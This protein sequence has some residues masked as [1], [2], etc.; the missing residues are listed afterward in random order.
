MN[1][2]Q[3]VVLL[4]ALL[5]GMAWKSERGMGPRQILV[6]LIALLLCVGWALL[7]WPGSSSHGQFYAYPAS[8]PLF[9]FWA[10]G[11]SVVFVPTFFILR[12]RK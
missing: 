5:F 8:L 10:L 12:G 6:M 2:L 11:W 7:T 1:L 4:S 9:T 3:I